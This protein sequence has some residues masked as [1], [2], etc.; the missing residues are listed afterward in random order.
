[1]GQATKV[2]KDGKDI[3]EVALPTEKDDVEELWQQARAELRQPYKEVHEKRSAETKRT[4]GVL[5]QLRVLTTDQMTGISG[6]QAELLKALLMGR[7]NT[8]LL[9]LGSNLLVIMLFT[10]S[11]FTN[12]IS[13][14]FAESTTTT[15]N[16]YL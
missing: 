11:V 9:F 4:D 10:S 15:F 16:P 14:H 13:S 6:A 8:V 3:L 2:S 1:M 7:T 12:F 5:L